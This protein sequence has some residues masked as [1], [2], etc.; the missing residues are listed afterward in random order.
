MGCWNHVTGQPL[1]WRTPPFLRLQLPPPSPAPLAPCRQLKCHQSGERAG[2]EMQADC[3]PPAHT[4]TL[5]LSCF[6][7]HGREVITSDGSPR[8]LTL[9]P[10]PATHT[11][12]QK[13]TQLMHKASNTHAHTLPHRVGREREGGIVEGEREREL[14]LEPL[15]P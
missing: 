6:P 15:T 14:H 8:L 11:H 7:Q 10:Q 3:L 9:G 2:Q 13:K 12:T 1:M 5:P 4:H